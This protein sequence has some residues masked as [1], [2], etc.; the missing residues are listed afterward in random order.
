MADMPNADENL[1]P[2]SPV[3]NESPGETPDSDSVNE[4]SQPQGVTGDETE[5]GEA[6]RRIRKLAADKKKLS[7]ELEYYKRV[8]LSTAQNDELNTR[9]TAPTPQPSNTGGFAQDEVQRAVATLKSQGFVTEEVLNKFANNLKSQF[10]V[11]S[12]WDKQ[13]AKNES[14]LNR[15]SS[16]L[17][18]YDREEVEEYARENNIA[19]PTA[20]YR[21]MYFDEIVDSY[22]RSGTKPSGKGTVKP[23]KPND[24]SKEALTADSFRDKF[25]NDRKFQDELRNNPGKFDEIMRQLSSKS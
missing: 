14:E 24:S 8:A 13:H 19:S 2:A 11:R 16:N 25:L 22:K 6:Q 3:G 10:D 5:G 4:D 1:Q 18:H 12:E 23:S 7:Q 21:D 15:K 17:P 20:A 9:N